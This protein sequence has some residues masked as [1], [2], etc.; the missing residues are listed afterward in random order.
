MKIL[1]I[2]HSIPTF[3][4]GKVTVSRLILGHLPFL[5][6]SYQGPTKN[7][8]YNKKFSDIKNIEIILKRAIEKHGITTFSTPTQIDGPQALKFL[9]AINNVKSKI[10]V[11]IKLVVCLKIPLLLDN[12]KIDDY[13][14]WITYYNMEKKYGEK[15][16]DKYLNDPILQA[17]EKWK[18]K[19]LWKLNN[20][21]AY[22]S[23]IDKLQIDYDIIKDILSKLNQM[24]ILY[25]EL[26]SETDFLVMCNH[27]DLLRNLTNLIF[28][29]F[30]YKCLLGC[31]HPGTTI[32]ILEASTINFDGYITPANKLG[33]MMF[34]TQQKSEDAIMNATKPVIAIKPFAGGRIR[35]KDAFEYLYGKLMI[36]S[37]MIGV[38]SEKE[39]D[40]DVLSALEILN[41]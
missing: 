31:H 19:F 36:K 28:N 6:E 30:R 2:H 32:P 18:E 1:G 13:R 12:K 10:G 16:L 38:G 26:G 21:S 27:L 4:I 39:L 5:G 20:I 15:I 22:S 24:D 29:N 33:I 35:P 11:D 34:P 25:V 14:R 9:K 23:E 17:R 41:R 7:T 37:C 40:D 8:E 3:N